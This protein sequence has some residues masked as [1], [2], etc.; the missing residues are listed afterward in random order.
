MSA[1]PAFSSFYRAVNA[2]RDPLPWQARLADQVCATGMWP[3][4]I[5]VPTGLGKTSCLDIAVY[6]LA[7]SARGGTQ[8]SMA[9][10]RIWYVVDRRLLIDVATDHARR[11]AHLLAHPEEAGGEGSVTVIRDVADALSSLAAFGGADGPLHVS[12]LRGGAEL[13]SRAPDPSQP[14]LV[15]STVAMYA[16]RLLFRGFGAS[17]SMRPIDAAHAGIDALVLL[18]EAHL[19]RPLVTLLERC[20]ECDLG[21]PDTTV[22]GHRARPMLV[23][24]T[25][26]GERKPDRFELDDTDLVHPLVRRR[27]GA[28]KPTR[29]VEVQ[30]KK[31]SEALCDAALDLVTARG[32]ASCIVFC[33]TAGRAREVERLLA[34]TAARARVSIEVLL[35]TGRSREREAQLVRTRLLDEATG[36]P[37]GRNT[38]QVRDKPLVV[39][40]TQTLEVGADLDVDALVSESASVRALT[41]RF[42]RLDRLGD[43]P[44]SA[45][46]ICH[47]RDGVDPVYGDEPAAVWSRLVEH[48]ADELSLGPAAIA[49]ALGEPADLPP[50]AAELLG[51]H[52]FEYAKTSCP[53]PGEPPVELFYAGLEEPTATLAL[54]WRAYLPKDGTRLVPSVREAESIDVPIGEAREV[55]VARGLDPVRRLDRD[56]A[57]LETVAVA[58]LVPGDVIV[59]P[60]AAGLYDD[61]GW[62]PDASDTVLDVGLLETG[63]LP[64]A[65]EAIRPLLARNVDVGEVRAL[66]AELE[67]LAEEPDLD[68]E[69]DTVSRLLDA[70][71]GL[72]PHEAMVP[73]EWDSY[74]D[75]LEPHPVRTNDDVAYLLARRE[76]RVRSGPQ[77]RADAFEELSFEATSVALHEHLGRDRETAARIAARLG[78]GERLVASVHLAG[79]A[80]DLGKA[81]PRFQRWLDPDGEATALVAKSRASRERIEAG[82]LASG[83]PRGGRHEAISARLVMALLNEVPI[84]DVDAD[85]VVHLVLSHHGHGRPLL[86]PVVDTAPVLVRAE[87]NERTLSASGD[88]GL[89]DWSQPRRFHDLCLRYG[90]WGLCL[91]ESVLRQ[92]DHAVSSVVEVA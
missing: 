47:P 53:E 51:E 59:L 34:T 56:A 10:R 73:G 62:S 37:A 18:D 42:G 77:V 63:T 3:S 78:M 71:R 84:E 85:L 6:A 83:W 90:L 89:V 7:D 29:L 5:A 69:T 12:Q 23:A 35:L 61:K 46:V 30:R 80:H 9:P 24:L 81:D 76:E 86:G 91:L 79:C 11:L 2:G 65:V 36:I 43:R 68:A 26:T 40:A 20:A 8:V 88:L 75:R 58:A 17:T 49:D 13:G 15:L 72:P 70:L 41:Q 74:L 39:V 67:D 1:L 54:C 82:R 32:A 52:L 87:M 38:E 28:V 25:A 31:L 66:L 27:L 45:A 33:N 55:L 60:A 48:G 64:L 4:E 50:R 16:S 14:A 92:A 44:H 19:A 22:P 21:S 57:A